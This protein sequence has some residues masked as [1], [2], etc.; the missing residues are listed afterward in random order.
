MLHSITNEVA[1]NV[2]D[3]KAWQ[4]SKIQIYFFTHT[5]IILTDC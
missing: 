1:M 4:L 3:I 2:Y 5:N